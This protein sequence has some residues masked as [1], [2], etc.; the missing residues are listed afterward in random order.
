LDQ[1]RR[2]QETKSILKVIADNI[3]AEKKEKLIKVNNQKKLMV[4]VNL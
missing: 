4:E 1:E 2:D 3:E